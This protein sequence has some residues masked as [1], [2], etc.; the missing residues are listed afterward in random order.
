MCCC[1]DKL[2]IRNEIKVS[3]TDGAELDLSMM[4]DKRTDGERFR[5][6]LNAELKR[7]PDM[8]R[9]Q[10][11][12]KAHHIQMNCP[13]EYCKKREEFTERDTTIDALSMSVHR[14]HKDKPKKASIPPSLC[15]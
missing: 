3:V 15:W 4:I 8:S 9:S 11:H 1:I 7:H 5:T 14:V 6:A 12:L 13:F 10:A 2:R